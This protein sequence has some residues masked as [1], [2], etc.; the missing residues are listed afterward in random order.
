[1][2]LR[3]KN[4]FQQKDDK[5]KT[6]LAFALVAALVL[7]FGCIGVP[8]EK[9]DAL[10]AS[11]DSDKAALSSSLEKEQSQNALLGKNLDKCNAERAADGQMISDR[12]SQIAS[13]NADE[14][15]LLA[16]RA[17]AD[18]IGQYQLALTY[19]NDAFGPGKIANTVR[20]NR[21]EAQVSSLSDPAL[22][23]IWKSVRN[24]QGITD[25][26]SARSKFTSAINSTISSL[27]LQIVDV[28]KT[29][30]H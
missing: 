16:A 28:V 19:Y 20:L 8:Q 11:C 29:P 15:V 10:K 14:A 9:Y 22:Y 23:T 24:C 5:M 6:A 25:C 7:L 3:S 26:E 2:R 30:A 21:I 1:M 13:L 4:R 12:D 27:A 18:K 17:K